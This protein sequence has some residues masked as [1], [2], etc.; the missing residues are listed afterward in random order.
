MDSGLA[1]ASLRRPGMT[2]G[3]EKR[4]FPAWWKVFLLRKDQGKPMQTYDTKIEIPAEIAKT[5]RKTSK[6]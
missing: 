1:F 2:A 4:A 5:G 6:K 3:R